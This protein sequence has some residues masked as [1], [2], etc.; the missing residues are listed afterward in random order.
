MLIWLL[1]KLN[2]FEINAS[3]FLSM[4]VRALLSFLIS[5]ILSFFIGSYVIKFL[6]KLKIHQIV[7]HDGP[8]SHFSK[9]N[10]PTMGGI[11]IIFCIFFTIILCAD[12]FDMY[13]WCILFA[14]ITYG[15]IGF[16]D[17]YKKIIKKNTKGLLPQWKYLLQS[18]LAII[19]ACIIYTIDKNQFN[20]VEI[21]IPF[22]KNIQLEF[23]IFYI[24]VIYFVIV[25]T[26][27]AVNLTDGLDGLAIISIIIIASMFTFITWISSDMRLSSIFHIPYLKNVQQLVIVCLAILGSGLGFLWFNTYPAQIFMGDVGSLSLGAVLGTISIL[28]HQEIL[29]V[30]IGGV[31]VIETLSVILQIISFKFYKKRIFLMAP[32]HHHYEL[33]GNPEPRIITRFFIISYILM[34]LSMFILKIK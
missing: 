13:I 27:N 20:D 31:F 26:S 15:I 7:R 18:I 21:F 22:F 25:G 1:K 10:T 14:L 23:G 33:M 12:L 28:L 29:L 19:L 32:I 8:S 2:F 3:V 30:F 9:E 34:I 24:F 5:L 17:D 11:I 4:N 6:K 16:I